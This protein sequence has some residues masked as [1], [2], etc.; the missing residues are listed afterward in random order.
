M[1]AFFSSAVFTHPA[2]RGYTYYMRLDTD[3][4]IDAPLCYDPFEVMHVRQRV[5]GYRFIGM[6][7]P[8][9]THGMWSF[10]DKYAR[11]HPEAENRLQ[12][13]GWKWPD[14]R[15]VATEPGLGESGEGAWPEAENAFYPGYYNNFE[16]VKL[17]AF[18]RPDVQEWL[19][20]VMSDPKRAYKYRWGLWISASLKQFPHCG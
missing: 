3:S 5:Y 6:D 9:V 1:C 15:D 8:Q 2:L 16:I 11:S 13:N 14:G 12:M 19:E 17:E 4:F 20:E 18:R 7:P 10:V